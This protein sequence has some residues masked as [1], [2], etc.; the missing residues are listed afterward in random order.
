MNDIQHGKEITTRVFYGGEVTTEKK[1][2][3]L[4]SFATE[5]TML[6]DIIDALALIKRRETTKLELE[7]Q[8]DNR[9]RVK[10]LRTWQI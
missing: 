4:S 1:Q 3:Q 9:G 7:I 5:D 10:I 8:I 6:K 2:L